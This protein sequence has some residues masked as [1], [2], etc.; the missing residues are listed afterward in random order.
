M[1]GRKTDGVTEGG[2][3]VEARQKQDEGRIKTERRQ[4][5]LR[6]MRGPPPSK[7]MWEVQ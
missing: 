3:N 5:E 2:G 4:V 7:G 6:G 1:A